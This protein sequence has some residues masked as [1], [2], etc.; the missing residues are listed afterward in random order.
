[1][2]KLKIEEYWV[3]KLS[4]TTCKIS[5][6]EDG[7]PKHD[8]TYTVAKTEC[9]CYQAM[10]GRQC[11]HM[12]IR[13]FWLANVPDQKPTEIGY[14]AVNMEPFDFRLLPEQEA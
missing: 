7:T 5:K 2:P 13:S 9:Q 4:D 1:M 3:T 12:K 8:S 10:K 11:R 14:D 6:V